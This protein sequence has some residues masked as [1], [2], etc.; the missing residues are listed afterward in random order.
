MRRQPPTLWR[1]A[2]TRMS[3]GAAGAPG[4]GELI[5]VGVSAAPTAE[6]LRCA[7][8]EHFVLPDHGATADADG[9]LHCR[10][11]A[12]R[13]GLLAPAAAAAAAAAAQPPPRAA[14]AAEAQA[15]VALARRDLS[16]A[17]A[18]LE[19]LRRAN[20]DSGRQL[21]DGLARSGQSL[22]AVAARGVLAAFDEA[23]AVVRARGGSGDSDDDLLAAVVAAWEAELPVGVV[24]HLLEP[25]EPAALVERL[26]RERAF[27]EETLAGHL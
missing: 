7:T 27:Y 26:R 8:C 17:I 5:P 20:T 9:E 19:R 22:A 25:P 23:V 12:S 3:P 18:H 10:G 6:G 4:F 11:C 13:G 24:Q 14:D 21:R 15:R 16:A 1:L 2:S